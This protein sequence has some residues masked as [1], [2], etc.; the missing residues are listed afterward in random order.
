M[1]LVKQQN[2]AKFWEDLAKQQLALLRQLSDLETEQE[3]RLLINSVIQLSEREIED[4]VFE[5]ESGRKR[6]AQ[7]GLFV[8][9]WSEHAHFLSVVL[10][11]LL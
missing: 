4:R 8:L 7:V 2:D 9:N 5:T 1:S 11:Y 10:R 6:L 3:R